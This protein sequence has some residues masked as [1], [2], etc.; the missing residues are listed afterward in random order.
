LILFDAD[1][2][3]TADK[4][5]A[6]DPF[7][8]ECLLAFALLKHWITSR[9]EHTAGGSIHDCPPDDIPHYGRTGTMRRRYPFGRPRGP[10][11]VGLQPVCPGLGEASSRV[12]QG[13]GSA[14]ANEIRTARR[15]DS[16]HRPTAT[17]G[18]S[19]NASSEPCAS[20]GHPYSDATCH[21][22]TSG[23]A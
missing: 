19:E 2:L 18:N 6:G 5:V 22:P 8:L 13:G 12:H 20:A 15:R 16:A 23:M 4:L 9:V 14:L 1:S 10:G 21:F 17:F 3:G 11:A 7:V